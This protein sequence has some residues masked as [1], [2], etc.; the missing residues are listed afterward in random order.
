MHYNYNRWDQLNPAPIRYR[1]YYYDV[2]TGFYYLESRYYDPELCRFIQAAPTESINPMVIDGLN[3][4]NYFIN[5]R[6]YDSDL[7]RYVSPDPKN[8]EIFKP[9]LDTHFKI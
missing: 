6:Y 7:C 1:G 5:N 8:G 4:Y 3:C 9:N 2:E